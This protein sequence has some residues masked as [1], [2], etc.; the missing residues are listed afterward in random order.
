MYTQIPASFTLKTPPRESDILFRLW[1]VLSSLA[2]ITVTILGC[3]SSGATNPTRPDPTQ[4]VASKSDPVEQG[5]LIANEKGCLACHS[6]EGDVKVGPSWKSIY[7]SQEELADGR[8][9]TVN[10]HYIKN[11]IQNPGDD[12]V[13]GFGNVMPVIS[14]SDSEIENIIAF[15]KSLE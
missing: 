9:A 5:K 11:S 12:I 14:L 2:L 7:G 8:T 10:E 3:G 1:M 6:T 4:P 13:K 15:I